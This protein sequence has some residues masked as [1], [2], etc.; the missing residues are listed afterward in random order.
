[1]IDAEPENAD[2]RELLARWSP[3]TRRGAHAR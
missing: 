1:V 3:R 2:A